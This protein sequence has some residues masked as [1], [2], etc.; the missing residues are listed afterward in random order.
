[1]NFFSY[2][3][4][5]FL[6][7]DVSSMPN[8]VANLTTV[9]A[10]NVTIAPSQPNSQPNNIDPNL[11]AQSFPVQ[12]PPQVSQNAPLGSQ[13]PQNAQLPSQN[14]PNQPILSQNQPIPHQIVQQNIPQSP[15]MNHVP[16]PGQNI[17][18][19][20]QSPQ[21]NPNKVPQFKVKPTAALMPSDDKASLSDKNKPNQS[22][23]NYTKKSSK[24]RKSPAGSPHPP[25]SS[26]VFGN[27][28]SSGRD[29]VQS[30]A[31]S[32]IS[33]DGAP[34]ETIEDKNKM[35]P[36]DKKVEQGQPIQHSM[37]QYGMYPFYGQPPYM[38]PSV[39]QQVNYFQ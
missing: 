25:E 24:N 29:E 2:C 18:Q 5:F 15:I 27:M 13:M 17:S 36:V 1:M 30:P 21:N 22:N 32:D 33:D 34:V 10:V 3:K 39:Q 35:A 19:V 26:R 8:S 38:V 20:P 12:L 37:P 4:V 11:Q 14:A 6:F 7:A 31:Y 28:E 23:Q 16:L 9:R